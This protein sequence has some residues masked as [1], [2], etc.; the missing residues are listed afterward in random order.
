MNS[1]I[2]AFFTVQRQIFGICPCCGEIFR[3]SDAD[4]SIKKK[5][6][7]DWLDACKRKSAHLDDREERLQERKREMQEKAKIIGRRRAVQFVKRID[8]V[9]TPRRLDPDDAKVIFHP[10]DYMV[11]NGMSKHDIVNKIVFL[12]RIDVQDARL[13]KSIENTIEKRNYEWQTLRVMDDGK[14]KN[15]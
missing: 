13:Q 9:F 14:V 10:V 4:I 8:P 1:E 7:S 2:M 5:F 3:L 12:D 15:E 6:K 11:F